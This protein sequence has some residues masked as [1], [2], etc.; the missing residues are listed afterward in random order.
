MAVQAAGS[1][2][3]VLVVEDDDV[4]RK[5]MCQTVKRLGFVPHQAVSGI[6]GLEVL[7]SA[8]VDVVI[9]DIEMPGMNGLAMM[10]AA[11][12]DGCFQPFIIISSQL[13]RDIVIRAL[14]LGAFDFIDKPFRAS[15]ISQVLDEAF[16]YAR[17]LR[18][19]MTGLMPGAQQSIQSGEQLYLL[20]I[21]ESAASPFGNSVPED[22]VRLA[23]EPERLRDFYFETTKKSLENSTKRLHGLSR[24]ESSQWDFGA[25]LR[26]IHSIKCAS[27]GKLSPATAELLNVLENSYA[28]I[29]VYRES[30]NKDMV[31]A[32]QHAQD[33]L[34]ACI[35]AD[36]KMDH[37][38]D[39]A[40]VL[41]ELTMLENNLQKYIAKAV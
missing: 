7:R 6:Q 9:S 1:S 23:A 10:E 14:K 27:S 28:L 26:T 19:F 38:P 35:T 22:L 15:I 20:R 8:S 29:R 37:L 25:L 5:L 40:K 16:R 18:T 24:F 2:A 31:A 34:S 36:W 32:L 17:R 4:L 13:K 3:Q 21:I 12:A 30:L 11:I 33:A 39:T 41:Q